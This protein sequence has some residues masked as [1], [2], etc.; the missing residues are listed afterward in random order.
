MATAQKS[1]VN[2]V[3]GAMTIGKKGDYFVHHLFADS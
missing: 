1:A 3:F 2:I